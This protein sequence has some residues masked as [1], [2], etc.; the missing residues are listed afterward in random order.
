VMDFWISMNH[1]LLL[2]KS[3]HTSLETIRDTTQA[4]SLLSGFAT[5]M[6][7]KAIVSNQPNVQIVTSPMEYGSSSSSPCSCYTDPTCV[8]P[9]SLYTV[10]NL[11]SPN[12]IQNFTSFYSI[13]GFFFDCYVVEATLKSNLASMFF[14]YHYLHILNYEYSA[15]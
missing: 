15:S 2:L 4:N 12:T 14:I 8:M 5:S 13:P 7:V 10:Q 3:F 6:R 9:A 1:L 11:A